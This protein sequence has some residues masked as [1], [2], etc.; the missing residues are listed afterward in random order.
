[1]KESPAKLSKASTHSVICSLF[2]AALI[3]LQGAYFIRYIGAFTMPDPGMH[4]YGTYALA[5]GQSFNPTIERLDEF[6]NERSTQVLKGDASYLLLNEQRNDLVKNII[7]GG[8]SYLYDAQRMPQI[9]ETRQN[10]GEV[11][12][13]YDFV[14][15]DD[16]NQFA[17]I[18]STQY[19]PISWLPSAIGLRVGME[20]GLDAYNA[21]QC[22]R[23]S[24]LAIF[25]CLSIA[26]IALIPRMKSVVAVLSVFPTTV[27]CASSLMCDSFIISLCTL[28]VALTLR[29]VERHAMTAGSTAALSILAS[30][31]VL[32]KAT[33]LPVCL[34]YLLLDK[35][36]LSTKKK[37]AATVPVVVAI[38]IY[39]MWSGTYSDLSAT[40]NI[41]ENTAYVLTHPLHAL[42]RILFSII[43]VVQELI[44]TMPL[45]YL[46]CMLV[47]IALVVRSI[48][49]AT[50]SARGRNIQSYRFVIGAGIAA[51]ASVFLILLF[52]LLTWNNADAEGTLNVIR[53][54]Q[55]R[56]LLPIL[57][58]ACYLQTLAHP[59]HQNASTNMEYTTT[60][61]A[62]HS[63]PRNPIE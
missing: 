62:T 58:L 18:R 5:T 51:S 60:T 40:A 26:S 7:S 37:A 56:Y 14:V 53:G 2:A 42:T 19:F 45:D 10:S 11:I 41:S 3:L 15:D 24:N 21:Y 30:L 47:F 59:Q 22:G 35:N 31:I 44:L 32:I 49:K 52:L 27:F 43:A 61:S 28:S 55:E 54:F 25:L 13:P 57:P 4:I 1:M 33:Y 38:L 39:L 9:E 20:L 12:V 46:V 8:L 16:V 48:N 50:H 63:A 34:G 23:V 36:V 17:I 6:G 29:C